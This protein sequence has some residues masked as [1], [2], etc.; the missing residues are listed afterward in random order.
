MSKQCILPDPPAECLY[1]S[2]KSLIPSL[3]IPYLQYMS[4]TLENPLS[5]NST[6]IFHCKEINCTWKSTKI[7]CLLFDC[8]LV[9]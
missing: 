6:L 9:S 5:A 8:E 1:N 4:R 3:V 2:W 7:L